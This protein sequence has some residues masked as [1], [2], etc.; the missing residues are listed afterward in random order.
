VLRAIRA[1]RA[2]KHTPVVVLTSSNQDADIERA[3][4]ASPGHR[5]NILNGNFNRAAVGVAHRGNQ[6]FTVQVFLQSC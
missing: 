1:D 5:A 2:A 4:M 3:Y 6:V